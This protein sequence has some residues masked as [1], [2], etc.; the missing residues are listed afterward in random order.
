MNSFQ[1]SN[2]WGHVFN[3]L[4][5]VSLNVYVKLSECILLN[6]R[7]TVC[8]S[9]RLTTRPYVVCELHFFSEPLD[10]L[11]PHLTKHSWTNGVLLCLNAVLRPKIW[12]IDF[13][14]RICS[15]NSQ[16]ASSVKSKLLQ[17]VFKTYYRI[18][19][20]QTIIN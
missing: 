10:Q 16:K 12:N 9:V 5:H 8:P 20:L 11:Q 2:D 15:F 13:L 18:K 14:K 4:S 1:C 6:I 3:G 19:F 17:D 7:L